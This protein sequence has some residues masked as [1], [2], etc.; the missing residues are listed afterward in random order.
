[1]SF[2][3]SSHSAA[4]TCFNAG[5][6]NLYRYVGND[7]MT[8][9]DPTGLIAKGFAQKL[10]HEAISRLSQRINNG[11]TIR[12]EE[13]LAAGLSEADAMHFAMTQRYFHGIRTGEVIAE[14]TVDTS[15][16]T[17]W[18]MANHERTV[19]DVVVYNGTLPGAFVENHLI[20]TSFGE[21]TSQT[22][23]SHAIRYT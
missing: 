16:I 9:M 23:S 2:H 19:R 11:E 21:I 14:E 3:V 1:M 7:P 12:Y 8:Y 22:D 5:E 10:D 6:T 15:N 20:Y 13:L 17:R 18:A 4:I